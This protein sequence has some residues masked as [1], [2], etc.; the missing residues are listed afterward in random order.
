MGP[1]PT[2]PED[3]PFIP[4][5]AYVSP[6]PTWRPSTPLLVSV[7][8][9]SICVQDVPTRTFISRGVSPNPFPIID[10]LPASLTT[11]LTS[12]FPS[13]LNT[14][15]ES[16]VPPID[17]ANQVSDVISLTESE[18]ENEGPFSRFIPQV[19]TPSWKRVP[20]AQLD[21][22]G[23]FR[24]CPSLPFSIFFSLDISRCPQGQERC[25]TCVRRC[26]R[27]LGMITWCVHTSLLFPI[28]FSFNASRHLWR[29][30]KSFQLRSVGRWP[31]AVNM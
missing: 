2:T 11:D 25:P 3:P 1:C 26:W 6:F 8:A 17:A 12:M 18:L 24:V 19:R 16:Q 30:G 4:T 31:R 27:S 28:F 7:G 10:L 29:S 13:S 22:A 5:S 14:E 21:D 15:M 23:D 9:P 20:E